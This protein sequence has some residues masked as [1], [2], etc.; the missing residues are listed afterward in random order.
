MTQQYIIGEFSALLG[1]LLVPHAVLDSALRDLRLQVEVSHLSGLHVLAR[2]AINLTDAI[3]WVTL[4]QGDLRIFCRDVEAAVALREFV[5][6]A[7]LLPESVP[8]D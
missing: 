2:R 4:E 7:N 8:A 1:D 6:C 3:C 5:I